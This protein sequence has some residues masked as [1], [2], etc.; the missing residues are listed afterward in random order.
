MSTPAQLVHSVHEVISSGDYDRLS[1]LVHP[2][3]VGH[4]AGGDL[5]GQRAFADHIRMFR[6]AFPDLT[7]EAVGVITE[8]DRVAWRVSARGTH[9]GDFMGIPATGR[10]VTMTGIDQAR[11]SSDGRVAE[12][13]SGL[14]LFSLLVALGA[15]PVPA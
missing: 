11:M 2:E 4:S 14:D 5:A 7:A 15:I 12:H 8:G 6:D 10:E 13:W 9:E 3:F 1:A